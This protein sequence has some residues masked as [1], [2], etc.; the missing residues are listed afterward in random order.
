MS[1]LRRAKYVAQLTQ[2]VPLL[3]SFGVMLVRARLTQPRSMLLEAEANPYSVLPVLKMV[4][5]RMYVVH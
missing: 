3:L 4:L 2:I 1:Y 5:T